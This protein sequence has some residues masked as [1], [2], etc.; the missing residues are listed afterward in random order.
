MTFEEVLLVIIGKLLLITLAIASVIA[1]TLFLLLFLKDKDFRSL[2]IK[3]I[4][5]FFLILM[6]APYLLYIALQR[7]TRKRGEAQ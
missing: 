3:G 5:A 6:T 2:I 4:Q 7:I 1:V